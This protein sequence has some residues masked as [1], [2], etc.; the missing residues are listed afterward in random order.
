M[1]EEIKG[2]NIGGVRNVGKWGTIMDTKCQ[3]EGPIRQK[4]IIFSTRLYT[5]HKSLQ[6]CCKN[7]IS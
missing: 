6:L 5:I 2:Y 7:K 3:V 4:K 1:S